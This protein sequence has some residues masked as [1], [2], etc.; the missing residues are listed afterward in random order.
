MV[1]DGE[2]DERMGEMVGDERKM[3]GGGDGGMMDKA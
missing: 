3:G 1:E 2:K